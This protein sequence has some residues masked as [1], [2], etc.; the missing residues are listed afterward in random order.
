MRDMHT[1]NGGVGTHLGE[2]DAYSWW[3]LHKLKTQSRCIER[4]DE[5]ARKIEVKRA[6]G[7]GRG[8]GDWYFLTGTPRPNLRS[9]QWLNDDMRTNLGGP[10]YFPPAELEELRPFSTFRHNRSDSPRSRPQTPQT[11]QAG[12]PASPRQTARPNLASSRVGFSGG[13]SNEDW[14]ARA[15][16]MMTDE[17]KRAMRDAVHPPPPPSTPPTSSSIDHPPSD[18]FRR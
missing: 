13:V 6:T 3:E 7:P 4:Q 8:P 15:N 1:N 18:R 9:Q 5:W 11:P 16:N 14:V 10:P 17:D 2:M 12:R